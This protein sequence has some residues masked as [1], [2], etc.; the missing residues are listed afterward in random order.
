MS[1]RKSGKSGKNLDFWFGAGLGSQ[2]YCIFE[3]WIAQKLRIIILLHLGLVNFGLHSGKTWQPIMF[4]VFGPSGCDHDSQKPI[5]II[6]G[7]TK[8][9]QTI[10]EQ[11]QTILE[12]YYLGNIR[13]VQN[14]SLKIG[15]AVNRKIRRSIGHVW[16]SWIWDQYLPENMRWRFGNVGSIP[17]K[18]TWT[19]FWNFETL[20]LWNFETLELWH[21]EK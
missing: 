8:I 3:V 4:M 19:V 13:I 21:F 7:D 16:E 14:E 6:F 15:K 5:S 18:K 17:T 12:K 20:Q 2:F 10:Q 9:L 11:S 1:N